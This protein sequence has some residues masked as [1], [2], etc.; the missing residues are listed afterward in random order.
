VNTKETAILLVDDDS[1]SGTLLTTLLGASLRIEHACKTATSAQEAMQL[2]ESSFF[3]LV[4]TD[5]QMPGTSGLSLCQH[6]RENYPHTVVIMLSGLSEIEYAIDS[7]RAGAFDYILKPIAVPKFLESIER[8]LE[9]QEALMAR[10]Y[11]EQSLEEEISDLLSLNK[12]LR[13]VLKAPIR[14]A[15]KTLAKTQA[16]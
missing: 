1:D 14:A 15:E 6:I 9:Y 12:R 11:C 16:G 10:H 13:S 5:I 8:A 7:M 4:I 2:L 3:H